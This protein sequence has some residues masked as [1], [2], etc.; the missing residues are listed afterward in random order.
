MLTTWGPSCPWGPG[1]RDIPVR[2]GLALHAEG[3]AFSTRTLAGS[4][5]GGRGP[6]V[7]LWL[8]CPCGFLAWLQLGHPLRPTW[9]LM[10]FCFWSLKPITWARRR[11]TGLISPGMPALTGSGTTGATQSPPPPRSEALPG[12]ATTTTMSPLRRACGHMMKGARAAMP[13]PRNTDTTV[14]TDGTQAAT[15]VRS[16]AGVLP[17]HMLGTWV[18]MRPGLTLSPA[19]PQPCRRRV[20]LGTPAQLNTHSHPAFHQHTIMPLTARRAP[21]RPT[22]GP[23][24]CSQSQNPSRSRSRRVGRHLQGHSSHSRHHPDRHPQQQHLV[25]RRC[26]SSSSSKVTGYSPPSRHRHR[27]GCS[28]RARQLPGARPPLPASQQGSPSQAP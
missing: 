3:S 28:S 6:G 21:G 8:W 4:W 25:S 26:N 17:N 20:S 9:G 19:L 11:Q 13:Q 10:V 7:L 18:A 16:Q 23:P 22:R 15:L 1:P 5:E 27:L 2:P 12:T 24:H 14:T